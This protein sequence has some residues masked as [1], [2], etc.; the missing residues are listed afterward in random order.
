MIKENFVFEGAP[1]AKAEILM[2]KVWVDADNKAT[3]KH[4]VQTIW[5]TG[6]V[7]N[8]GKL[9]GYNHNFDYQ[10]GDLFTEAFTS[11]DAYLADPSN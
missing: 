7:E 2:Q 6:E 8:R 4:T 10:G 3:T 11:L 9:H 5:M 1:I